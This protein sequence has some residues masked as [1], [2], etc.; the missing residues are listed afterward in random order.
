MK[1]YTSRYS[2]Q[3]G[4]IESGLVPV[5]ITLGKPKFELSYDYDELRMLAPYGLFGIDDKNEFT[6]KYREYLN[7]HGIKKIRKALH[8]ISQ[9]HGGKGLVLLCYEDVHKSGEWCHRRLF[10]D[11]WK[12]K[13]GEDIE[14]LPPPY[15]QESM[16]D[17][18]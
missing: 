8:E 11:W 10:A 16:F 6:R 13:T 18:Q 5:R 2:N 14:E 4:I 7:Q 1:I 17:R 15:R 9:K 12:D 3:K